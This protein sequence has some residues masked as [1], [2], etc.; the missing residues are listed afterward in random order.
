[1]LRLYRLGIEN[2]GLPHSQI[3]HRLYCYMINN[4]KYKITGITRDNDD[5]R[6]FIIS[7]N[8]DDSIVIAV[9]GINIYINGNCTYTLVAVYNEFDNMI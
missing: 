8:D 5:E 4:E 1:M 2:I 6:C 9:S 3:V 7:Y